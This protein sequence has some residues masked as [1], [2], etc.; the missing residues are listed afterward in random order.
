MINKAK[1]RGRGVGGIK[2]K[3]GTTDRIYGFG[4]RRIKRTA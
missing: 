2:T 1:E 4:T 3:Q